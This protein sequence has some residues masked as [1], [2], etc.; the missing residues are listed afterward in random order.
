MFLKVIGQTVIVF[1]HVF[2]DISSLLSCKMKCMCV[3]SVV[4]CYV[5]INLCI[6]MFCASFQ[7][8]LDLVT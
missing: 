1:R 5:A 2:S 8:Y 4:N 3:L 7:E 6:A